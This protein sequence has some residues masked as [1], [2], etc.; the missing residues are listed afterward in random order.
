MGKLGIRIGCK[1][2]VVRGL[3]RGRG[4]GCGVV[5][6]GWCGRGSSWVGCCRGGW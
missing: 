6:G 3:V 5:G 1:G 2:G 4:G